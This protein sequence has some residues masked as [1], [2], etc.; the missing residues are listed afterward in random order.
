MST[1]N[2]CFL[3]RNKK[4]IDT[5]WLKKRLVKSYEFSTLCVNINMECRNFLHLALVSMQMYNFL[6]FVL[7]GMIISF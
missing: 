7:I 4:N 5:F 6:H 1:N 2:I 3:S